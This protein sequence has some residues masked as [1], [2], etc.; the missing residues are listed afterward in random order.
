MRV[1]AWTEIYSSAGLVPSI[2]QQRLAVSLRWIEELA[3]APRERVLDVGCGA[4][5]AAVILAQRGLV[6]D[7]VDTVD[8]MVRRTRQAAAEAG[9]AQQV[10]SAVED[11]HCL[12]FPDATFQVVLA[13]GVLP[14]V[15]AP[16]QALGEM[17]RVVRPNGYVL[18]SADNRW[19]LTDVLD[20]WRSPPLD[21]IK[22]A[23]GAVLRQLGLRRPPACREPSPQAVS[24]AELDRWLGSVGLRKV[25]STTLGFAHFTFFGRN[26]FTTAASVRL[27]CA[28]QMLADRNVPVFRRLGNQHIVLAQKISNGCLK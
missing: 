6:V 11:V 4:G 7:A 19:R 1:S 24:N 2:Y 9:L 22:G 27:H 12:T 25:K 14:W 8:D 26:L 15:P 18:V 17:A 3:L 28:L 10:N 16:R 5:L 21:A 13:L 20:P 23:A